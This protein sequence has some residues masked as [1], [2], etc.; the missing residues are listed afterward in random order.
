M[1]YLGELDMETE[2]AF[3]YARVLAA[4]KIGPQRRSLVSFLI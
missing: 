2:S 3:V 4:M 1:V